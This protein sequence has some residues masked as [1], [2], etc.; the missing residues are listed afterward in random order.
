MPLASLHWRRT[1]VEAR[2][3]IMGYERRLTTVV[4]LRDITARKQAEQQ[5]AEANTTLQQEIAEHRRTEVALC[6]AKDAAETTTRAKSKFLGNMSHEL[7]TPMNGLLGM[8]ELAL[9]TKLTPERRHYLITAKNSGEAL[10]GLL[11]DIPDFSTIDAGTFSLDP[12]PFALR[13]CLAA[14][15]KLLAM[16]AHQ[17]GLKLAHAIHPEVLDRLVGDPCQLS[18]ILYKLVENAIKFTVQGEVMVAVNTAVV[19]GAT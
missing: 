4:V 14:T 16:R 9:D 5:L 18:Q 13:D 10:L 6:Q 3:S 15:L 2:P 8:T 19:T 1:I 11:N 12:M 7:R 17:Q